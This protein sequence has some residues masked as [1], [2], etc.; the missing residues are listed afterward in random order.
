MD[1]GTTRPA[2]WGLPIGAGIGAG[3]GLVVGLLVDQMVMG[4]VIGAAAGVVSGSTLTA[5]EH[6]PE[7]RRKAVVAKAFGIVGIGI[8]VVVFLLLRF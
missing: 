3:L 7:Q 8:A 6:V 2:G 1:Q 4:M 5:L